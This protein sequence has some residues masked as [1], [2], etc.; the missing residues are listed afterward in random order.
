MQ[1]QERVMMK[2]KPKIDFNIYL[3]KRWGMMSYQQIIV[4]AVDMQSALSTV[5]DAVSIE[6]LKGTI[7]IN[8]KVAKMIKDG[9]R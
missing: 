9:A 1:M 4:L 3:C 7:I 6:K 8:K 2:Q 5:P